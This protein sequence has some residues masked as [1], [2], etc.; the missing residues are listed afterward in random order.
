MFK[1]NNK[2]TNA[3]IEVIFIYIN[4]HTQIKLD[5]IKLNY[6]VATKNSSYT[7]FKYMYTFKYFI[8]APNIT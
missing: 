8:N 2:K 4:L 6:I 5:N 7:Y 3:H 1:I